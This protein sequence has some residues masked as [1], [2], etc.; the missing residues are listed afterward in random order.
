MYYICIYNICIYILT[1]SAIIYRWLKWIE[2][3]KRQDLKVMGPE[4]AYLRYR[5]CHLHFEEKWY[6]VSKKRAYLYPD[7]IP[8]IFER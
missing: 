7:A 3:C 4:Y 1:N 8:T 6:K 2:A 5:M